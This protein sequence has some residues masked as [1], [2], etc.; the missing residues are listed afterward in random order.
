[1]KR[2]LRRCRCCERFSEKRRDL[3]RN[4]FFERARVELTLL[5]DFEAVDRHRARRG[6]TQLDLIAA[7]GDD[8]NPD[9]VTDDDLLVQLAGQNEHFALHHREAKRDPCVPPSPSS[10]LR[11]LVRFC[12]QSSLS[13]SAASL[14][15]S[16]LTMSRLET[17]YRPPRI[18]RR[19]SCTTVSR[20][21][22]RFAS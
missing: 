8:R 3:G 18:L 4:D 2:R 13:K 17:K 6:Y 9:L 20:C 22:G 14:P 21:S 5:V 16:A 12:A 1:M 7:D 11:L 19:S 10:I 15:S